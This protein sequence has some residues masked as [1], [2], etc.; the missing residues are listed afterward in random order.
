MDG[1]FKNIESRWSI[2][3]QEAYLQPSERKLERRELLW[4]NL[5]RISSIRKKVITTNFVSEGLRCNVLGLWQAFQ[6]Y[7][8][9]VNIIS[10]EYF[11]RC[12]YSVLYF[13]FVTDP[14]L[15]GIRRLKNSLAN[16]LWAIYSL[17]WLEHDWAFSSISLDC[18]LQ[19][20]KFQRITQS[21]LGALS[22]I[23]G[24]LGIGT[25]RREDILKAANKKRKRR[26]LQCLNVNGR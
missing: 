25:T 24:Y 13:L 23:F 17:E 3:C 6:H 8:W 14:I 15:A 22:S 20:Y 9:M 18:H 12:Y 2:F 11:V 19:T 26:I 16:F 4:N 1:N 10:Y 5:K 21:V 7:E